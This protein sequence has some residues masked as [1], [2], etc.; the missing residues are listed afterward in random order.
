MMLCEAPQAA[1]KM[2]N[3]AEDTSSM[4]LRPSMSLNLANMTMTP[5][6]LLA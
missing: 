5:A 6:D 2:M 1:E 4:N 3:R